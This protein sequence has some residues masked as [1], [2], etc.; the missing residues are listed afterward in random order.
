MVRTACFVALLCI[1]A[2]AQAPGPQHHPGV[3]P[4][5]IITATRQVTQFS[6]LEDQLL[7]AVQQKDRTAVEALLDTT[8][9]V[10][11]SQTPGIPIPR[12][13][14]IEEA[15]SSGLSNWRLGAMAVRTFGADVAV[16][17]FALTETVSGKQRTHF[18]VDVWTGSGQDW[19]CAVRYAA[20]TTTPLSKKPGKPA[21]R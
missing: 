21:K 10:W 5:R 9:E 11:S 3:A 7:Q 20:R 19:K 8:Y 13:D 17:S 4:G 16:A 14:W 18:I 15:L 1:C 6:G 2:L 12:E